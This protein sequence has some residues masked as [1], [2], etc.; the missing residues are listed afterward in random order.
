MQ[1]QFIKS[2][3]IQQI[4]SN[5]LTEV[6]AEQPGLQL[7]PQINGL[8][9]G[10]QL[11]GLN[12]DYTL[13]MMDGEPVVGRMTGTLELGR[14]SMQGIKKI[15]VVKGPT[16]SLYGSEALGGVINLI[17]SR[18]VEKELKFSARGSSLSQ[19]YA[20]ALWNHV[21]K[22][23]QFSLQADAFSHSGLDNEPEL[24]GKTISP[25][26]NATLRGKLIIPLKHESEFSLTAR[27]F[28]EKQNSQ[29]Q[30]V[31]FTDS[32]Q[33][34]GAAYVKEFA[35][36]PQYMKKWKFGTDLFIRCYTTQ[37]QTETELFQNKD[38]QIYYQ[39]QF[40]QQYLKPELQSSCRYFKQQVWTAGTGSILENVNTSRYGDANIRSQNTYYAFIQHDW[41]LF[42]RLNI[43]SGL[44]YDLNTVYGSQL[45][46]KLSSIYRFNPNLSL[47]ASFGR[48][49]KSPDFRQ[50]Y[51]NFRNNAAGYS[52]FGTEVVVDQ[53]NILEKQGLIKERYMSDLLIQS[54]D[55]ESSFA[56]QAG[57][58]YKH[59]ALGSFAIHA[60][61]NDLK[62][63][64]ETK[65]VALT[66][67]QQYIY[68][69]SNIKRAFTQGIEFNYNKDLNPQFHLQLNYHFLLAKDKDVLDKIKNK[70]LYGRDPVSKESYLIHSNEYFGLA[71]RSR[72]S[73][74]IK[75][76][77]ESLQKKWDASVRYILRGQYGSAATAGAVGGTTIPSSD[78]NGNQ[79]ID[80]YDEFVS[81][82]GLLHLSLAHSF[83]NGLRIQGNVEN[84][85]NQRDLVNIPTL[86]GRAFIVNIQYQLKLKS[87]LQI[88]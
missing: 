20:S 31:Q 19:Y 51:L 39:D 52:V 35:V 22:K 87:K 43:V 74:S 45:N 29:H 59:P 5:R 3:E 36:Y 54:L 85:F 9:T 1:T 28:I 53:L 80:N 8:G 63:L 67:A 15:E 32:I 40:T 70:Q 13:I 49:F 48:G 55:P 84:L 73:G 18:P 66:T 65:I 11:H 14:I 33:V 82:Y 42:S 78:R 83:N 69:Y 61:R 58:D 44:R 6:L 62:G 26:Q 25:F 81:S 46:P 23:Y 77:Y 57:I 64:I 50:L 2:K 79:V 24:Y 71:E 4:G 7:V 75:I 16:S 68:S 72:H 76:N 21:A 41:N 12:A 27:A 34:Y 86:T 47:K 10:I 30:V 37:Y 88:N 17:S 38:N 60:Y 56:W